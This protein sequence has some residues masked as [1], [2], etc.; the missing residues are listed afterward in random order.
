MAPEAGCAGHAACGDD[1]VVDAITQADCSAGAVCSVELALSATGD[2]H[3]NDEY[4]YRF[5]AS[6]EPGL[7]YVGTDPAGTAV[8]SKAAGDWRK[9]ASKSGVMTVKLVSPEKGERAVTGVFKL[10]VCSAESCLLDQREITV[11]LTAR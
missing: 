9:T 1:F 7:R 6:E 5:R 8:F 3:L 11:A 10:S 4:P 2:F